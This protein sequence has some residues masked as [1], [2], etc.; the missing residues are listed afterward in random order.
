MTNN[1]EE[2]ASFVLRLSQKIYNSE[3]GEPQIQWR[4]SI[5]HVQSGDEQ[6]FANFE[7]ATSFMQSKLS[8]ITLKAIEDKPEEEQKGI[9][10]MSFD[11]W[12]KM[13]SNAPKVVI[14]S[15]KDPKKQAAHIQ[16]QLQE[17]FYHLQ[18]SIG[19]KI[20]EK[21]GSRVEID[22][23][24]SSPKSELREIMDTLT[25]LTDKV[26]KLSQ[27]VEKLNKKKP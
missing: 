23:W 8:D 5:R 19:Q 7:R 20:E 14:D 11:F 2:T 15:F 27:Q 25:T 13:A 3:D 9:I 6:R 12:K 18:E 1:K 10:S 17:Q 16:E 21:I 22:Q 4:G 24:I 26:E